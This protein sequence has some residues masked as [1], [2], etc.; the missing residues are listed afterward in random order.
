MRTNLWDD[1]RQSLYNLVDHK[2]LEQGAYVN[3]TTGTTN[4]QGK[5]L[6]KFYSVSDP[7]LPYPA[8]SIWQSAFHNFV[9][10]SGTTSLPSPTVIS[11]VY[12]NGVFMSRGSGLHIDFENGRVIFDNP[13]ATTGIVQGNFS[14][15]EY[16]FVKPDNEVAFKS[17]TK[18]VENS[19]VY[20]NPF[21]ASPD[22]IYLP[23]LFI[24][25]EQGNEIPFEFGGPKTT[26]PLFKI[27]LLGSN[28][29]HLERIAGEVSRIATTS[30][31]VVAVHL[32]PKFDQFG[33][34]IEP[35]G[36]CPWYAQSQNFAYVESVKY[37]RLFL[38]SDENQEPELFGGAINIEISAI[39]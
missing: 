35:Y 23:A 10:E 30:V 3:V 24:E 31:P 15:K 2:L 25:I 8:G 17:E 27:T 18:Y 34:L 21:P 6:S 1:M 37:S 5:D 32:G 4:N 7:A 38:I 29:T 11:G 9:Y 33:D 39:R 19:K 28:Q 20:I 16:T 13:I 36:F 26:K 12:V 14:Y 22:T